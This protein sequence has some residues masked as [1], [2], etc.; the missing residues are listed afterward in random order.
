[1]L[2][3]IRPLSCSIL[4][5]IIQVIFAIFQDFIEFALRTLKNK[6]FSL[7]ITVQVSTNT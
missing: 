5:Q 7:L 4:F 3:H 1:M 6:T 2:L